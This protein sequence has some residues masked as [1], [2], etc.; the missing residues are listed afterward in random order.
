MVD[1]LV[2]SLDDDTRFSIEEISD[3]AEIGLLELAARRGGHTDVDVLSRLSDLYPKIGKRRRAVTVARRLVHLAPRDPCHH[4]RLARSLAQ[5]D[6]LE[7]ALRVLWR[8][9]QLGYRD[10]DAVCSDPALVPLFDHPRFG[11]ILLRMRGD[12]RPRD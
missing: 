1:E 6:D 12:A 5:T 8:A 2:R 9:A 11:P 10:L 7:D 3:R 4:Y